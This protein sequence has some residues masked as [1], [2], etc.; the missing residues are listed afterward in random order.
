M[1]MISLRTALCL[2]ALCVVAS[3]SAALQGREPVDGKTPESTEVELTSAHEDVALTSPALRRATAER[4][5]LESERAP[6]LS[7]AFAQRRD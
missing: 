6:R 5:K 4:R 2:S 3:G 7:N 1:E